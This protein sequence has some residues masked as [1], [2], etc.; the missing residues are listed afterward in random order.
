MEAHLHH[1]LVWRFAAAASLVLATSCGRTSAPAPAPA[2]AAAASAASALPGHTA[3]DIRFMTGMIGHHQQ[4]LVMCGWAGSHG[5]GDAVRILCGRIVVAQQD[6]IAF[7][8]RWLQER[9]EPVPDTAHTMHGPLMPGM[10][11]ADELAELDRTRGPAYDEALLRAMIRH[12]QGAITMVEQLID[13]PGAAQDAEL[14]RFVADVNADQSTE[15][16]AMTRLLAGMTPPSG[17]TSP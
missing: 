17:R 14:F 15:I 13:T 7:M 16:D 2:P 9:R 11:T 12:H 1:P 10:L 5:A 3:A 4:A 8:R 6:E